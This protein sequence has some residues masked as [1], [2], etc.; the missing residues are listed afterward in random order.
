MFTG[1]TWLLCSLSF[2]QSTVFN[3]FTVLTSSISPLLLTLQKF[4]IFR[5]T[6]NLCFPKTSFPN[7]P[8]LDTNQFFY[9]FNGYQSLLYWIR[10]ASRYYYCDFYEYKVSRVP[11]HNIC[12]LPTIEQSQA[13]VAVVFSLPFCL[14][15]PSNALFLMS[16]PSRQQHEGRLFR[17]T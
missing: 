6:R 13:R 1:L 12:L 11:V 16:G 9:C 17:L 5:F 8:S 7:N 4:Q 10:T 2:A 15:R 3:C 14:L